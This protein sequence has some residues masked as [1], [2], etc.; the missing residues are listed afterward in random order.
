M[1]SFPRMHSTT[2]GST[3]PF[4]VQVNVSAWAEAEN[5]EITD[6][7]AKVQNFDI[8]ESFFSFSREP[9]IRFSSEKDKKTIA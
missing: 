7:M 2:P 6:R 8:F 5:M 3:N 4:C 9:S 1:V